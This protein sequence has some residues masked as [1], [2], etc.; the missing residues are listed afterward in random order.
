MSYSTDESRHHQPANPLLLL[1]RVLRGRYALAIVLGGVLAVPCSIAGYFVLQPKYTSVGLV[2]VLVSHQPEL[3][4]NELND[5]QGSLDTQVNTQAAMLRSERVKSAAVKNLREVGWP[6]ATRGLRMLDGALTVAPQRRTDLVRVSATHTDAVL[7]KAAVNEILRAYMEIQEGESGDFMKLQEDVLEELGKDLEARLGTLNRDRSSIE[8][9]FET[10][11][12]VFKLSQL[13]SQRARIE[14]YIL[15]DRVL[16][17]QL[18]LDPDTIGPPG[19]IDES[20]APQGQVRSGPPESPPASA[21]ALAD[22]LAEEEALTI[23]LRRLARRFGESHPQRIRLERD[24]ESIRD[25][26]TSGGVV[27]DD[28]IGPEAQATYKRL[29]SNNRILDELRSKLDRLVRARSELERTKSEINEIQRKLDRTNRSLD[30]LAVRRLRYR[31]NMSRAE[32]FQLGGMPREPSTDRR[33]PLAV[34][35]FFGGGGLG[36]GLVVLLGLW[37]SGLR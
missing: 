25:I 22:L 14:A 23:T 9:N 18:G 35:G 3:D 20:Q 8:T 15:N 28:G 7:A 26:L 17:V 5:P 37:R 10:S 34:A 13:E 30:S 4:V 16:L 24:L 19:G 29:A 27:S 1:H 11:D 33:I 2:R 32:V 31:N 21:A 12:P 36:V 6:G